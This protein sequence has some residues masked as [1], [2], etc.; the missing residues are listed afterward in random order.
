M[1]IKIGTAPVSWGIMEVEGWNGQAPYAKVLDE[2]SEAGYQGTELGPYGYLPSEPERLRAELSSRELSMI[3]AF[4]PLPLAEPDRH[5]ASF[6]EAMKVAE[7][8]A[9]AEARM[10][11]L[12]GDMNNARMN[13]AGRV[14]EERDGM[15]QRDWHYA[16]EIISRIARAC[17]EMGLSTAFHHH[18][19]TLIETPNEIERLC[20]STDSA[21][22]GLCLDTGHYLYGGGNPVEA[23]QKYGSRIWHLHLKDVRSAVLGSVRR[24]GVGFLEAVRRDVF[25]EL[26]EGAVDFQGIKQG[27]I[28][29]GYDGWAIVEQD[30]DASQPGVQPFESAVRSRRYLRETIGV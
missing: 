24:E 23:V 22:I 11:V 7:L 1:K 28:D 6:H 12:A 15:N 13:V 14:N 18:A 30:V 29:C 25:C 3:A 17:L 2:M 27:L 20:A 21:L 26:G 4:V 10:I 5:D 9:S 19:G 8:L 16:V